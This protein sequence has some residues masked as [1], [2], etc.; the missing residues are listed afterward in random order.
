M[1]NFLSKNTYFFTIKQQC[2]SL[3]FA[4]TFGISFI[5][6]KKFSSTQLWKMKLRNIKSFS[7]SLLFK[8]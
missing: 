3:G 5:S 8:N 6:F 2:R 1:I 7:K 4:K